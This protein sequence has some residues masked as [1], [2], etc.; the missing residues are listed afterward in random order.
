MKTLVECFGLQLHGDRLVGRRV[1]VPLAGHPDR[2]AA[3]AIG[4]EGG[5][6]DGVA[7]LHSTSWRW[8]AE[9]DALVLTYIC[10]PDP[11]ADDERGRPVAIARPQEP[12]G[13]ASRPSP[14]EL[15]HG[16]VLHHGVG[17]LAWLAEHEPHLVETSRR[18]WPRIWGAILESGRSRAGQLPQPHHIGPTRG[19]MEPAVRA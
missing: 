7:V 5:D 1:E 16:S 18:A 8:D 4:L 12:L 15:P 19:A 17:H 13:T 2:D 11:Q 6:R 3:W 14:A 10:C 9:A